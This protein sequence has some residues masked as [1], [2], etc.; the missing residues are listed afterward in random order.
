MA[1]RTAKYADAILW[2]NLDVN[3]RSSPSLDVFKSRLKKFYIS[4]YSE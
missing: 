1:E 3:V 4:L 2:N